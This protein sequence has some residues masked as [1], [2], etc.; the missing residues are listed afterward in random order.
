[1]LYNYHYP[2]T[3]L[4]LRRYL[5]GTRC[6][7]M[8][9]SLVYCREKRM[10]HLDTFYSP[11]CLQKLRSPKNILLQNETLTGMKRFLLLNMVRA[12]S[13]ALFPKKWFAKVLFSNLTFI[14]IFYFKQ[15]SRYFNAMS[16]KTSDLPR[17][18][19]LLLFRKKI[20]LTRP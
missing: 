18:F 14:E 9:E 8:H 19:H 1:M 17:I 10:F 15:I 6:S 11:V 3:I 16:A 12:W 13:I 4:G 7:L 20:N 5:E 2:L